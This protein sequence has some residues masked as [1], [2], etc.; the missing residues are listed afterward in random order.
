MGESLLI[1]EVLVPSDLSGGYKASDFL[2]V[3]AGINAGRIVLSRL[4]IYRASENVIQIYKD[5]SNVNSLGFALSF[6]LD[7]QHLP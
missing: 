7:C 2:K 6:A 3:V 4:H 5:L 1:D